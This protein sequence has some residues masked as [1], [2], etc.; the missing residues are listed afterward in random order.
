MTWKVTY[1]IQGIL[2][3][4]YLILF[5]YAIMDFHMSFKM[6]HLNVL[7]PYYKEECCASSHKF[8]PCE[9]NEFVLPMTNTNWLQFVLTNLLFGLCKFNLFVNLQ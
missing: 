8:Q 3:W 5:I 7:S 6:L 2:P 4:H 9:S 1:V